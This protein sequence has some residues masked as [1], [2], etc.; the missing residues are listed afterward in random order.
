MALGWAQAGKP[1]IW[2]TLGGLVLPW[3][4]AYRDDEGCFHPGR[5][6]S[7]PVIV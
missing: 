4:R 5:R 6:K 3:D 7:L 1:G 2:I